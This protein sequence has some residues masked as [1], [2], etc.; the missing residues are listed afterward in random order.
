MRCLAVLVLLSVPAAAAPPK[1]VAVPK[2][3]AAT[4]AQV[5]ALAPEIARMAAELWKISETALKETRSAPV[6]ADLLEKEGFAVQRGV[7]GMP[8]AF[9][10][11]FGS[12][13]PVIGILAEYDALPNI[14]NEALPRRAERTD[15]VKDGHGCGHNLFGAASVGAAIS[16]KRAL[17]SLGLPGTLKLFGTPA[18]ETLVGKTYMARDGVFAGLDAALDWHPGTETKVSNDTGQ[19]NNN[20][21]VEFYGKAS[22]GARDPWNGRSALDAVEVMTHAA[23]MMREHLPTSA[24]L[25]YVI[26]AG[27]DVPNVVPAYARVWF[28]VRDVDRPSVER[29]YEWLMQIAQAAAMAT[30]TTHK[31]TLTTGVHEYN[32]NRPL[33]EAMKRNLD[34]VGPPAWGEEEQRFARELQ[35]FLKLPEKGLATGIEPLVA[36]RDPVEGGSTD[37]AE[38]SQLTPTV[39]LIVATAGQDLPWH[40]W[41]TAASHGLPGASRAAVVAAKVLAATGADLFTDQALLARAQA[42]FKEQTRPYRSPL[43][44]GQKVPLPE[45]T[46]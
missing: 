1:P 15:G 24:R 27:G 25:H 42:A 32:L 8:T 11:T 7:A 36:G 9:V 29:H 23:N 17:Q 14:G 45:A 6:L 31:V 16:L 44:A 2:A 26:S 19:A 12:G 38:V 30:Q 21:S 10:A 37:S 13:K 3:K 28:F 22:H 35:G 4:H 18:E 34:L 40:S 5:D 41:A 46:K 43:P 33:Q 20:F 39:A